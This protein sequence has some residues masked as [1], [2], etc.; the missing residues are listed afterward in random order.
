MNKQLLSLLETAKNRLQEKINNIDIF[1]LQ[2]SD[3]NKRYLTDKLS[4]LD[5]VLSVYVKILY[6]S[7]RDIK[8][9]KLSSFVFVDYGGGSGLLSLLA[10][11]VGVGTVIY[12]DIYDVCCADAAIIS[13]SL[14]LPI[15]HFIC[16]DIDK[17][18]QLIKSNN[19]HIDAIASYDVVEHIYD[20]DLHFKELYALMGDNSSVIYAS[21]AN[22]ANPLIVSVL[23]KKQQ[24]AEY[25][26]RKE[27]WGDKKRDTLKAYFDARYDII[28]NIAPDFDDFTIKS[29]AEKTRGLNVSDIN[30]FVEEYVKFGN[31]IY[32]N[33]H[34]NNTC[35]PY[36]GNWCEHLME[37][38]WLKS[39]VEAPGFTCAII[40]GDYYEMGSGYKALLKRAFNEIIKIIPSKGLILSPYYVICAHKSISSIK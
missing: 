18:G 1:S 28:K 4:S 9:E 5:S 24:T 15:K 7:L 8:I 39:V 34:K 31:I 32:R 12:T 38:K 6:H 29:L 33:T 2:I 27:S 13:K 22:I 23:K 35:D 21:S 14:N 37:F 16:G 30:K 17:L 26:S 25:S 10:V 20:V 3:Y 36:T 40:P 19:I 11:Q